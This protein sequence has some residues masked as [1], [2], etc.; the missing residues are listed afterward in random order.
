MSATTVT[1]LLRPAVLGLFVVLVLSPAR[2]D[3]DRVSRANYKLANQLVRDTS[4]SSS[5]TLP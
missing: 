4:G 3:Q 1:R 2:A 5:T